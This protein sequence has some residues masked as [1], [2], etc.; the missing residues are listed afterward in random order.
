M[1]VSVRTRKL[2]SGDME[3][4]VYDA[5]KDQVVDNAE[6]LEGSTKAQVQDHTPKAHTHD[7]ATD[8]TNV[9]TDQHH[10]KTTAGELNLAD[11][12]EKNHASLGNVLTDQHHIKTIADELS[13]NDM[14]EKSHASL[15]DIN[16]DVH[17]DTKVRTKV[18]NEAAIG[19]NKILVYDLASGTLVYEDKPA[20]GNGYDPLERQHF[21]SAMGDTWQTVHTGNGSIVY[22]FKSYLQLETGTSESRA[23]ITAY[24]GINAEDN[25]DFLWYIRLLENSQYEATCQLSSSTQEKRA[26]VAARCAFHIEATTLY[27]VT[28][29]GSNKT[30]TNLGAVASN[31]LIPL[32][33]KLTSGSKCEFYKNGSLVAT[34]TTNLPTGGLS[35][36]GTTIWNTAPFFNK[37]LRLKIVEGFFDY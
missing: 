5:D 11:L 15:N 13:L 30:E 25:P 37:K 16:P 36:V 9:L 28:A 7:H 1:G 2:T 8:L 14:D 32:R 26:S 34:H 19:D 10:P 23:A 35:N 27:A 33:L 29:D 18:V 21:Y 4:R 6:K 20:G 12:A 31:D 3:R 24:L 22:N 17:A